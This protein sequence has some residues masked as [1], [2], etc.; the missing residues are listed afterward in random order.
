[1]TTVAV[2]V[3]AVFSTAAAGPMRTGDHAVEMP[4]VVTPEEQAVLQWESQEVEIPVEVQGVCNGAT[5]AACEV[6]CRR[7]PRIGYILVAVTCETTARGTAYC[8]C[9]RPRADLVV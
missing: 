1:M 2:I 3:L 9:R 4:Q 6:V 5:Y 7:K 8:G